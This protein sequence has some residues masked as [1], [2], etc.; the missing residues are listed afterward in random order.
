MCS[1]T[2]VFDNPQIWISVILIREFIITLFC[3][4]VK[5]IMNEVIITAN[6]YIFRH[7]EKNPRSV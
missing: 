5:D 1:N 3:H 2:I 6:L 7:P 4:Y